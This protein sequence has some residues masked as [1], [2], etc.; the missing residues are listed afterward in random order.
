MSIAKSEQALATEGRRDLRCDSFRS[1]FRCAATRNEN[2]TATA[3]AVPLRNVL[4]STAREMRR[5][6]YLPQV[7]IR[8]LGFFSLVV[9]RQA[10]RT[11]CLL[12]PGINFAQFPEDRNKNNHNHEQQEWNVHLFSSLVSERICKCSPL[13]SPK[14]L[15]CL[16]R[17]ASYHDAQITLDTLPPGHH[18]RAIITM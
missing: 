18:P 15:A 17:L 7:Q 9:L 6:N 11:T 16:I 10:G 1:L 12:E 14:P 5:L 13:P 3:L 4:L 2:F 8:F